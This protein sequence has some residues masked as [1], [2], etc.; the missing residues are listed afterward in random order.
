MGTLRE[1]L[2]YYGHGEAIF[3]DA[4]EKIDID[5]RRGAVSPLCQIM[6]RAGS[7]KGLGRHNYTCLYHALFA[8]Y[9]SEP[10]HVFELGVGS[11]NQQLPANM[12]PSGVPGASLRG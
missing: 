5:L 1:L 9:P 7:D 12:G 6:Q 10:L 11:T 2:L 3:A 4:L 8:G